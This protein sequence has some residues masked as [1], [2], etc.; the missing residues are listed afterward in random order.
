MLDKDLLRSQEFTLVEV[1]IYSYITGVLFGGA[2]QH[3][4]DLTVVMDKRGSRKYRTEV[5][6]YLRN[7]LRTSTDEGIIKKLSVQDSHRNNLLQLAD[8]VASVH[9]R[10]VAGDSY[11]IELRGNFLQR[12]QITN[13]FWPK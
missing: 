9:S 8:Y 13:E 5:S 11:A 12:K 10:A 3:L 1:D 6:R 4:N 7:L 2:R